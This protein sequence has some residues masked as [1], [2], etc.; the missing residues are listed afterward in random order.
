MQDE[1]TVMESLDIQ[2]VLVV[3]KPKGPTSHDVVAILRRVAGMRRVGHCG[4]LDPMAEGVLVCCLGRATRVVPYLVGLH[5]E[6]T[7]EMVLG[8][9]SDTYDAKG[10]IEEVGDASGV[11]DEAIRAAFREQTGM[12]EQQAPSY[13]AIKVRGKKLYEYARAGEEVPKKIRS[14]WVERFEMLRRIE[15]RVT[16][17]TRVG[18]GTYVRSLAHDVGASL[19]C[20]AYLSALCRTS[21]GSF[22]LDDAVSLE[23]LQADPH[24][25]PDAMLTI[26]QGLGHLPKLIVTP[27][28]AQGLLHGRAFGIADVL[29]CEGPQPVGEP[30]L[31]LSP[32]GQT[33]AIVE[34]VDAES[35]FRPKSVLAQP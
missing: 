3:H 21:V 15:Q 30:A 18:S 27:S 19:G 2:G 26:S 20:G 8:S 35:D 17:V 5:K 9:R 1:S 13:S 23:L 10:V 16:F 14:V 4:T 33:L 29:E 7:G 22:H 12:I 25:L 6:Y 11:T 32:S 31:A 24:V 34:A 28:A